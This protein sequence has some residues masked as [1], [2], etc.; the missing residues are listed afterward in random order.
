M[1]IKQAISRGEQ[2]MRHF[3]TAVFILLVALTGQTAAFGTL[4]ATITSVNQTQAVLQEQGFSGTCT[5]QVSTSPS[6]T[7]L[8]PDVDG[9]E[10][11]GASTDDG[12]PDTIVSM[13]RGTKTV[14]LGHL[15]DDRVLAAYTTY[16][17]EVSGC[18]GPVTGSFTTANL[19]NGVTRT[20]QSPFNAAKWGNLGLPKFDWTAKHTYVDP[21]TGTTL[22]PMA[23]TTNTWRSGCNI[24]GCSPGGL[25]FQDWAGGSGWN[26]PSAI[27]S[28]ST[29]NASTNNTNPLDLYAD[30]SGFPYPLP[31]DFHST[32]EDVGVLVWGGATGANAADR[33][34]DVCIFLNP[35]TGCATNTVQVVLPQGSVA[36]VTSGSTDVDG[37]FPAAFPSTPFRGWT[38]GS[39]PLIRMENRETFGTATVSGNQLT[40]GTIGTSQHFSSALTAGQKIFLSGSSCPNSL[41]TIAGPPGSPAVATVNET[42]PAGS[43][44]FRAYGWGIRVWKDNSNGTAT[45]GLKY[46][47]AGSGSPIGI[48]SGGDR[49]GSVP[50]VSGDG[51]TGYLCT[52]TSYIFGN[53]YLA[54]IATDGTTRILWFQ[55]GLAFS[56]TQGNVVY[57]GQKNSSGGW[58]V[59]QYTYTGDYTSELSY[60]YTCGPGGDCPPVANQVTGPVDLMPH[61]MNMDLDQQIEANQGTTLPAYNASVYGP[62]TGANAN[63]AYYGTSG[64]FAFFCNNY[65]GQGQ[66]TSG[67]PGWCAAVDLSQTPAKV[68]R[69]IHTLDG[70]GMPHARFGS[71]HDTLAVDSN[72]N[73][74]TM[75]LDPLN[76]NNSSTLFGGPF[77]A[78]VKDILLADGMTWSANTCLDWPPGSGSSCANQSYYRTCP[79]GSGVYTECVTFH[80]PQNGVCSVAPTAVEKSTWP[81]AWNANYSQYP[82]MQPGDN[83]VDLAAIGGFDAEHFRIL[84]TAPD[85]GNTLRVV[86]ARNAVYDYCSISPWHGQ[87]NPL[88]VDSANQFQHANGWTLTMMPGSEGCGSATFLQEETTGST[89]QLGRSFSLHSAIGSGPDGPNFVTSAR[90][91][92]D[93]PF[94]NLGQ[95]PPVI[96]ENGQPAF[97]GVG[98]LIGS[99]LQSYTDDSH[100]TAGAQ[101]YPWALDMNPIVSCGAEQPG[102]GA[103]RT[104]T[105]ISGNVYKIQPIGSAL[106]SATTYKMQPMIGWAGRYQLVDVSGP[107]SSVDTTPYSMCFALFAGECHAGSAVND[108]YVNVPAEYDQGY[109]SGSYSY[110]SVPCVVFGN[111]APA[112]G[113]RQFRIYASD[114]NGSSS[115]FISNGWSSVGRHYPYTHTTG[116]PDGRWTM[117]MGTNSIDGFSMTGFMISLPPWQESSAP[118]NDFKTVTIKLPNGLAYAQVLFGYSRYVGAGRSPADGFFCTPRADSCQNSSTAPFIFA[119]EHQYLTPCSFGCT[120]NVPVVGPN[121]LYY[122]VRRS[123]NGKDWDA[124]EIQAVALP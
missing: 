58:T 59:S 95:V 4:T 54:F 50:V 102:C 21:M 7:P 10:Y 86:A 114:A 44:T 18:G 1:R 120:I 85:T 64:H 104:V 122:E 17:Y 106:P 97:H 46:K 83:A 13:S 89:Q 69:L 8:L 26:N 31:Y 108:V 113:I 67:G 35:V 75:T 82:L 33:T 38:G 63:V 22:V 66:T 43:T 29:S 14:T 25:T 91:I 99:E 96:V 111:N 39:T 72:P 84:S 94:N 112:G 24:L 76:T 36:P 23:L 110:V 53:A 27:L 81:C 117:L 119:S 74:V 92:F 100:P 101:G 105:P 40:I 103:P 6:M 19:S 48:Q 98:A 52:L 47:L 115:R 49:C 109:C 30:L 107:T 11:A 73:T 32:L 78:P 61:S 15:T 88:A 2:L 37:A 93:T 45:V 123:S 90:T 56:D 87:A 65:S 3:A 16:Y 79:A 71:L 62:W 77:Q 118:D 60:N 41:C 12:R 124:A 68:V 51:K 80:L 70:T 5:I 55:S 116:Y 57:A 28:G 42:P 34:V 20:E 121:L 9:S